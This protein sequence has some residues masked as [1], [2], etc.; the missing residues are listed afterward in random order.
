MEVS[1]ARFITLFTVVVYFIYEYFDDKAIKD[2]REE[3]I[4]LKTHEFT[5]K[6]TLWALTIVACALVFY[7]QTP[8]IYPIMALVL[9]IMYGEIAAKIYYRRKI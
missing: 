2:E 7:P 3:L 1:I 8:A 4:R 6:I 5:Q 9:A